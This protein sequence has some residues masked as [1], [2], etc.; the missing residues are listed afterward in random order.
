MLVE[1]RSDVGLEAAK[2]LAWGM[3]NGGELL[4]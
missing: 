1:A 2:A 4:R 3:G